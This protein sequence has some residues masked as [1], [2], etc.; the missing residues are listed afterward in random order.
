VGVKVICH[1]YA[2]HASDASDAR[3]QGAYSPNSLLT[4]FSTLSF[5][6]S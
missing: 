6:G 2:S 1:V 3:Y 5:S 4:R